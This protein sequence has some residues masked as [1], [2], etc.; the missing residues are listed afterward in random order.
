VAGRS[1]DSESITNTKE[2]VKRNCPLLML[3]FTS[4]AIAKQNKTNP[5]NQYRESFDSRISEKA[6]LCSKIHSIA[7]GIVWIAFDANKRMKNRKGDA[8]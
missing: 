1:I 4:V 2:I 8:K 6:R 3:L 7:I 5:T